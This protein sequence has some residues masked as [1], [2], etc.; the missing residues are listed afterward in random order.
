MPIVIFFY[1]QKYYFLVLEHIILVEVY[2]IKNWLQQSYSLPFTTARKKG[3]R[4]P[5]TIKCSFFGKL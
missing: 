5:L 1:S 2:T 4:E 3:M